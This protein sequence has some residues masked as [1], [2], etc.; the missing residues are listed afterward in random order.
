MGPFSAVGFEQ[1]GSQTH[2]QFGQDLPRPEWVPLYPGA[3][4]VTGEQGHLGAPPSGFHALEIVD[5]RL[6]RRGEALLYRRG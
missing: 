4:V 2:M 3:S 6:A 1:D 5:A